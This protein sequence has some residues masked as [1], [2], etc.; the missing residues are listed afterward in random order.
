MTEVIQFIL[1]QVFLDL[2][3]LLFIYHLAQIILDFQAVFPYR[4]YLTLPLEKG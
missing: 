4:K 1:P 2:L 3:Y